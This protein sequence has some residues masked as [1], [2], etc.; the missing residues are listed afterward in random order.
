MNYTVNE[1]SLPPG[2][3]LP[4]SRAI[5]IAIIVKHLFLLNRLANQRQILCR[6]SLGS[7]KE[8]LYKWYRSH[9]QDGHYAHLWQK[10]SKI[11]FYRTNSH[12]IMKLCMGQYVLKL[13]KV[14]INDNRELTLTH[15][16]TMSKLAKLVFVRIV[17]PDIK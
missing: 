5:Y 16:K 14:Y 13:Y 15:F 2:C 11:F 4:L 9:D 17:G 12:M 10:L 8:S 3:C 1:K 6:A 7:R